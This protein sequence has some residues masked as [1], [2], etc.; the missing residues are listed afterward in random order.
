MTIKVKVGKNIQR[1]RKDR[2]LTQQQVA[3]RMGILQPAYARYENGTYE[4]DYNKIVL[5]CEVLDIAPNELFGIY[6]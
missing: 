2:G 3:E 5:L 1:A 4:L 6:K